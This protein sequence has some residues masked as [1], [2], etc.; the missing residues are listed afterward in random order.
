VIDN[1]SF[2]Q[3]SPVKASPSI[4]WSNWDEHKSD[5]EETPVIPTTSNQ[6]PSLANSKQMHNWDSLIRSTVP[7]A[8]LDNQR[9]STDGMPKFDFDDQSFEA[10]FDDIGE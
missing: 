6:I 8:P 5:D 9:Q 3:P 4:S 7:L 2:S 1:S 10:M